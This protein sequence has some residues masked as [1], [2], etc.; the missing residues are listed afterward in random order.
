MF[1]LMQVYWH[2]VPGLWVLSVGMIV[3]VFMG[4]MCRLILCLV[5][6]LSTSVFGKKKST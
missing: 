2:I 4:M 5:W 6:S 1:A 3:C